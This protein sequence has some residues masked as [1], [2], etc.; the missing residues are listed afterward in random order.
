MPEP[1]VVQVIRRFKNDVLMREEAQRMEM[2]TRYLEVERRLDAQIAA[3]AQDLAD[4]RDD[5]GTVS[6]S[7]LFEMHRYKA[8]R[9]QLDDELTWYMDDYAEPRIRQG[10]FSFMRTG[11]DEAAQ[12]I[13]ASFSGQMAPYFDRLPIEATEN[14][15]GL[16]GDG[17]PLRAL[18]RQAYPAT[19]Q[20]ITTELVNATALG[21]NPREVAR[22]MLQE[23]LATGLNRA[24]VLAR[25][26]QLRVYR[27]ASRQQ[28]L[29]SG[30]V[31]R[32][33]RISARNAR[34]CMACLV[35]D[36]EWFPISKPITDHPNGRC[37]GVPE[38]RGARTPVWQQGPSWFREQ[39]ESLQVQMMGADYYDA[40]R[41]GAFKLKDLRSTVRNDT[42]GDSPQ[43]T[44][45][46]KLIQ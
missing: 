46:S 16:C 17:S 6:E 28:Y 45:L 14:M 37:T 23:K 2:A 8:M 24:M 32:F 15:V 10:Q 11:L 13:E 18:L 44:P 27:E 22:R 1:L 3:L 7:K 12:A 29:T 33:R 38:V 34:T 5:G 4:V 42:W 19:L 20:A 25:T 39:P 21:V 30:L 41:S 40:W 36:G 35:S 26:E 9:A 43:V 31:T